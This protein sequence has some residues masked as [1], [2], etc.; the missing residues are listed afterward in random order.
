MGRGRP[1]ASADRDRTQAPRPV[2]AGPQLPQRLL[3]AGARDHLVVRGGEQLAQRPGT[4]DGGPLEPVEA[5]G[6]DDGGADELVAGTCGR[7]GLLLAVTQLLGQGAEAGDVEPAERGHQ[8][9]GDAVGVE[10]G[11]RGR[12]VDSQVHR[13]PE[14]VE[15]RTHGGLVDQGR[16]VGGHLDR[17]PGGQQG[18]PQG[19][20]RG[21]AAAHQHRHVGPAD[22][23]LEVGA[24]Q[25][26][27]GVLHLG[28]RGVEVEHLH[29]PVAVGAASRLR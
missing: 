8:Q 27:G 29:L 23:V 18:P 11:R 2:G 9:P 7:P 19:R 13:R 24:A 15:Q 17:H 5:A 26:V 14:R 3:G 12:V 1:A 22:A 21:P 6:V 28:P 10:V 20:D 16:V 25:Q 4:L